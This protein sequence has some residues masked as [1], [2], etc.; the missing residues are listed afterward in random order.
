MAYHPLRHDWQIAPQLGMS[1]AALD[2]AIAFHRG[3]ESAW[4]RDFNLVVVVRWIEKAS[5]DGFV[6]LVLRSIER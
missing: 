3:H 6:D 2:A 5:L 4:P 1:R